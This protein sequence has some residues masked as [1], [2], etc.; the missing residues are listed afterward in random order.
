L[1]EQLGKRHYVKRDLQQY[2]PSGYH[3]PLHV[4]QHHGPAMREPAAPPTGKNAVLDGEPGVD[5]AGAVAAIRPLWQTARQT[6]RTGIADLLAAMAATRPLYWQARMHPAA[7]RTY[8][9]SLGLAGKGRSGQGRIETLIVALL[10]QDATAGHTNANRDANVLCYMAERIDRTASDADAV[11]AVQ[12]IGGYTQAARVYSDSRPGKPAAPEPAP[13]ASI[14]DAKLQN[15]EPVS[16]A[17]LD[18]PCDRDVVGVL[19]LRGRPGKPLL[20]YAVPDDDQLIR[21]TAERL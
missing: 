5:F 6:R 7:F 1:L 17:V 14:I 9:K 2:L 8:V 16:R 15:Y 10:W 20:L 21:V 12:D 19:V 18:R 11:Q 13:V 4:P 3:N